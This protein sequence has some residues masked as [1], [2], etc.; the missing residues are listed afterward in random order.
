MISVCMATCN[1]EKYLR[2]QIDSIL[3]QLGEDD[4]LIISDDGSTDSTLGIINAYNDS[5]IKLFTFSRDK[6]AYKKTSELITTNFEHALQQAQGNF[7]FLSD[8]DDIWLPGKV[9]KCMDALLRADLV[10]HDCSVVDSKKE[11]IYDSYFSFIKIKGGFLPNFIKIKYLGCCMA[12]RRDVL[13]AVL[14]M[15]P[16]VAHDAWICYLGELLFRVER[17]PVLLSMYRRHGN[18]M[19]YASEK[20]P[21]PLWYKIYYRIPIL[22][23]VLFR[24]LQCKLSNKLNN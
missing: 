24:Y 19:S 10:V 2:E 12:F 5:R 13:N 11:I 23:K 3:V 6:N 21:F 16:S 17:I 7:I 9:K 1:G 20:S 18:N 15:I 4:E 22:C 14:P 8:Q